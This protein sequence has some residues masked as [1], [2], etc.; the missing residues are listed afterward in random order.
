MKAHHADLQLE[1]L[2]DLALEDLG[3]LCEAGAMIEAEAARSADE[4][5]GTA[6]EGGDTIA[7]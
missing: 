5:V 6:P 3:V 1:S 2:L 4:P 7:P